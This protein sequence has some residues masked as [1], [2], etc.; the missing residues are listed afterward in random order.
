M[1]DGAL[2]STL[3]QHRAAFERLADTYEAINAPLGTLGVK[4]LQDATEA[5]EGGDTTYLDFR[6]QLKAL[7]SERNTVAGH[8]IKMMESAVFDDLPFNDIAAQEE[9]ALGKSVLAAAP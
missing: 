5:I 4:T 9:V 8:M 7:L 2:P 1:T 6:A 3:A